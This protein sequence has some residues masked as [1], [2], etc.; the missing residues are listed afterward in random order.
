MHSSIRPTVLA[1]AVLIP[2]AACSD[3]TEPVA[4]PT[5]DAAQPAAFA[6]GGGKGVPL[7]IPTTLN[8]PGGAHFELGF[9][10]F[11][12][13]FYMPINAAAAAIAPHGL[14]LNHVPIA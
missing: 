3:I 14:A 13:W 5:R 4:A 12:G 7:G 10:N 9:S 11:I 8:L 2:L 6:R 1:L